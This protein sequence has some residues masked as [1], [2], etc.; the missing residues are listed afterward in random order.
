MNAEQSKLVEIVEQVIQEKMIEE[1]LFAY[2]WKLKS[3]YQMGN[4]T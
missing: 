3:C 2:K 4:R 1:A